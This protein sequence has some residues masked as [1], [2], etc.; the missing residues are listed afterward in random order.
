MDFQVSLYTDRCV[1]VVRANVPG[2]LRRAILSALH[3]PQVDVEADVALIPCMRPFPQRFLSGIGSKGM[4]SVALAYTM[5]VVGPVW[6]PRMAILIEV[7][8]L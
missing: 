2:I 4:F 8:C 7:G 5:D 1:A 3:N 6:R